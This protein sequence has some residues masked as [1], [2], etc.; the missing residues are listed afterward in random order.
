MR[1]DRYRRNSIGV[2]A[3]ERA[4]HA[5]DDL[6]LVEQ[7][8]VLSQRSVGDQDGLLQIRGVNHDPL[9]SDRSSERKHEYYDESK[10]CHD[11][12]PH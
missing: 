2:Q 1:G 6:V 10:A 9:R 5:H 11:E 4:R 8:L 7:R 12:A 3:A